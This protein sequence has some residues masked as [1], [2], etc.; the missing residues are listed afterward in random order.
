MGETEVKG[1][2]LITD[3]AVIASGSVLFVKY[4]DPGAYDGQSGWFLPDSALKY[5]EHPDNAIKR[6]LKEQVE[7]DA[8]DPTLDHIESFRGNDGSWHLSFHYKVVLDD[9]PKTRPTRLIRAAEWFPLNAL[10]TKEEV[11]HHGWSLNTLKKML[12]Q[13]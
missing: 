10:P 1:Y 5:L 9:K 13:E 3:V 8:V 12:V 11:A 6:T 7:L 4:A 2:T